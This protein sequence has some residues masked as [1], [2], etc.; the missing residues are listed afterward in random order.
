MLNLLSPRE[1]RDVYETLDTILD[2]YEYA[3]VREVANACSALCASR[4]LLL[5]LCPRIRSELL[6]AERHLTLLTVEG[7]KN[8]LD[9]VAH[10][11]KLLS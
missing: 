3:E 4:V 6:N 8:C 9:L 11:H 5:D 2:L 1:V 10:L 7:K